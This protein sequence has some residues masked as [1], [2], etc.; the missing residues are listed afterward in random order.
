MRAFQLHIANMVCDRCIFVVRQI[1]KQLKVVKPQVE[2]GNVLF[3]SARENILQQLTK[4]L[5]EVG[6]HIITDREEMLLEAI[7]LEVIRYMDALEQ[8]DIIRKFSTRLQKRLGK[9]YY[10]LSKFFR[11]HE[12]ITL[13][14]YVI[15]Q[16][17]ERVKR[18][19][20]EGELSL[21]EIAQRLHYS[22]L[23][24]LS[25]QFRSVTGITITQ[26]RKLNCSERSYNS[27]SEAIAD[28]KS[29][30][31]ETEF[32]LKGNHLLR[33]DRTARIRLKEATLK[34]VYRFED[35]PGRFGKSAL[36]EVTAPNGEKGYVLCQ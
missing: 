20:C 28:L 11:D 29:Q 22:S 1:L 24:H 9:N 30:G 15:R 18:L 34:A 21:K 2:L 23:Q 14:A 12:Q 19:L 31:Y 13:E 8:R 25:A 17:A 27:L 16:K 6:L 4:K 33:C 26:F 32:E 7:K 36:F 35:R 10:Y 5:N 3:F